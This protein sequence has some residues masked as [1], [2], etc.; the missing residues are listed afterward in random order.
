M[1]NTFQ[2]PYEHP[3]HCFLALILYIFFLYKQTKHI[4]M[5]LEFTNKKKPNHC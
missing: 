5:K 4:Y 2:T 1:C 3:S